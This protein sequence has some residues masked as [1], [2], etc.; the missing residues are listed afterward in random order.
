MVQS[1]EQFIQRQPLVNGFRFADRSQS[2]SNDV[3]APA[4]IIILTGAIGSRYA[5][6]I[7]F[8]RDLVRHV[9]G[10]CDFSTEA[11][12]PLA[13]IGDCSSAIL[14][15]TAF[16][17]FVSG[18]VAEVCFTEIC[19]IHNEMLR[20]RMLMFDLLSEYLHSIETGLGRY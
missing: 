7:K 4:F 15:F 17:G 8:D 20:H 11:V 3:L 13:E 14:F 6:S 10:A 18:V 9:F 1:I 5:A 16:E 19:D 2:H 12:S